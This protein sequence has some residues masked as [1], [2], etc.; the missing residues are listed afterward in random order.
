MMAIV[1][2]WRW[3]GLLSNFWARIPFDAS[4]FVTVLKTFVPFIA[5]A[6]KSWCLV[7]NLRRGAINFLVCLIVSWSC[8][9]ARAPRNVT[10]RVFNHFSLRT[11]Q[12]GI[13]ARHRRRRNGSCG[14]WSIIFYFCDL[15]PSFWGRLRYDESRRVG[16]LRTIAS[17]GGGL[18]AG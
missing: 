6:F 9:N 18:T 16:E 15:A 10:I 14:V 11:R 1:L 12:G 5:F 13:P 3:Y 7:W 2:I 17:A 4:A 8:C